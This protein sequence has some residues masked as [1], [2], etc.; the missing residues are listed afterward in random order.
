M[1]VG[2]G[3]A[4][5]SKDMPIARVRDCDLAHLCDV[6]FG[7]LRAFSIYSRVPT[8]RDGVCGVWKVGHRKLLPSR[9]TTSKRVSGVRDIGETIVSR[10]EDPVRAGFI[11]PS[12][13]FSRLGWLKIRIPNSQ[14]ARGEEILSRAENS[15]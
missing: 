3:R 11:S 15:Q 14:P 1:S 10:P 12:C 4:R 6:T 9:R 5:E 7:L 2:L 8:K 13:V